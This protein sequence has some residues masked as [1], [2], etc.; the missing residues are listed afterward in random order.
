MW[1][2][3]IADFETY[4]PF[5]IVSQES[6]KALQAQQ[7][8]TKSRQEQNQIIVTNTKERLVYDALPLL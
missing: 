1:Y 3:L 2:H 5:K 8:S 7:I 6:Q 4:S